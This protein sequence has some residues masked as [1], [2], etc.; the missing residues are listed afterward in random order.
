MNIP[1]ET[2][3]ADVSGVNFTTTYIRGTEDGDWFT[4]RLTR[5]LWLRVVTVVTVLLLIVWAVSFPLSAKVEPAG[6][7]TLFLGIFGLRSSL[8]SGAPVFP[9]LIDYLS[10]LLYLYVVAMLLVR[11]TYARPERECPY[12][13]SHV[14]P[15]ATV[16]AACTRL[17]QSGEKQVSIA[18]D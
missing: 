17:I 4:L 5:P 11:R 12:C 14:H 2:V 3:D 6:L 16:C 8:L 13:K 7:L 15:Q 18:G 10:I 9:S 1:V